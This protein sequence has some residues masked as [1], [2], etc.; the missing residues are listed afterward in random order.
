MRKQAALAILAAAGI[1]IL[2]PAL[3]ADNNKKRLALIPAMVPPPVAPLPSHAV[4]VMPGLNTAVRQALKGSYPSSHFHRGMYLKQKGDLDGALIEFLKSAQENPQN[5]NAFYEQAV[6]F[7]AKGN[8]KLAQS[9]LQQALAVKPDYREA[10]MLLASV[11]MDD[12]QLSQAASELLNSLGLGGLMGGL[13]AKPPVKPPALATSVSVASDPDAAPPPSL[14]Q[15]PHGRLKIVESPKV[16]ASAPPRQDAFGEQKNEPSNG[17]MPDIT[18][19]LKGLPGFAPAPPPAQ[20]PK[21]EAAPNSPS[22]AFGAKQ[23]SDPFL[24]EVIGRQVAAIEQAAGSKRRKKRRVAAWL[25]A[26]LDRSSKVQT[27][28]EQ[29]EKEPQV[30]VATKSGAPVAN[31]LKMLEQ[32]PPSPNEPPAPAEPE[33]EQAAN[34]AAPPVVQAEQTAPPPP[35]PVPAAPVPQMSAPHPM[36]LDIRQLFRRAMAWVPLPIFRDE[37]PRSP[38]SPTPESIAVSTVVPPPA[39]PPKPLESGAALPVLGRQADFSGRQAPQ[40]VAPPTPATAVGLPEV[41]SAPAESSGLDQVLAM[42]P[43]DLAATVAN[44]LHPRPVEIASQAAAT[45]APEVRATAPSQRAGAAAVPMPAL[46]VDTR[47][48]YERLVDAQ[49]PVHAE[50]PAPPVPVQPNAVA[51]AVPQPLRP[52]PV[53]SQPVAQPQRAHAAAPVPVPVPIAGAPPAA[54]AVPALPSVSGRA[55]TQPVMPAPAPVAG[56]QPALPAMP[57]PTPVAAQTSAPPVPS[58]NP[59]RVSSAPLPGPAPVAIAPMPSTLPPVAKRLSAQGFKFV[60]PAISDQKHYVLTSIKTAPK[61]APVTPQAK[62][63]PPMPEDEY[64]KRMKYLLAHGTGTLGPGEAFMFSEETG[65]GV[66]FLRGGNSIRRKIAQPQ[67]HE[68][69]AQLRRPDILSAKGELQYNLSL[70]GKIIKPQPSTPP[71]PLIGTNSPAI[72]AKEILGKNDGIFGWIR[73]VFRF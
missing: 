50:P 39:L 48:P 69:I 64:A 16:V 42:L 70:L 23:V 57:A 8:K 71:S 55:P 54:T 2:Q 35:V 10:R 46:A 14:I 17:G 53:P 24:K 44:V 43:K 37:P 31:P 15:T 49:V 6:I 25:D 58:A 36:P 66:L 67:D 33:T 22:E 52:I 19:L 3:A 20:P 18:A 34:A 73:N 45:N 68:K 12:G 32:P 56:R 61:V 63:A 40:P 21:Q 27:E 72:A 29:E 47:Q 4:P 26:Y 60:A 5:V 11:H 65:E 38:L 30:A 1:V 51:V 59:V 41:A 13:A 62:Q 28:P 7:R 9:A